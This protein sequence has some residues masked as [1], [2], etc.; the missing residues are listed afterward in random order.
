MD[1]PFYNKKIKIKKG[2]T[3]PFTYCTIRIKLK[4]Y[5]CEAFQR[6]YIFLLLIYTI[7]ILTNWMQL[8]F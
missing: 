8:W 5:S 1:G 2:S 6:S 4:F 3:G 7:R